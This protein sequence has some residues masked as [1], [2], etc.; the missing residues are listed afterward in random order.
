MTD[1][2]WVASDPETGYLPGIAKRTSAERCLA[3]LDRLLDAGGYAELNLAGRPHPSLALSFRD[4]RGVV[5]R[6]SAAD[7]VSL[8]GGDGSVPDEDVLALPL[9]LG[10]AEFTGAFVLGADRARTVVRDFVATGDTDPLGTWHD[11]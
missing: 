7:R 6:F 2:E 1:V 10:D 3:A 4:G 9:L 8:L 11:L 5:H